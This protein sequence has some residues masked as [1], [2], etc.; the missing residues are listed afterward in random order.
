MGFP[1]GAVVKN[2]LPMQETQGMQVWY[3]GWEDPL[4]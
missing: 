1:G 3:L 2:R 4:K